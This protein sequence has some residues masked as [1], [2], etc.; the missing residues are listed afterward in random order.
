MEVQLECDLY[1]VVNG[2]QVEE[3]VVRRVH[4]DA[5]VQPSIP[6]MKHRTHFLTE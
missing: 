2:L 4:T 1:E 3:V 6:K 5:E